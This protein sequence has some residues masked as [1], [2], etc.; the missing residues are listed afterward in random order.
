MK[1]KCI[2]RE[3]KE[4]INVE[5][6]IVKKLANSIYDYGAFKINSFYSKLYFRRLNFRT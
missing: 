4:E 2:V 6:E 1:M 3:I 5:I